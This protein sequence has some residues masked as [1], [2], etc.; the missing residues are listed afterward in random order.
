MIDP[1]HFLQDDVKRKHLL[2]RKKLVE[3]YL[4]RY[5]TAP[6]WDF[7]NPD[8][9]GA[10]GHCTCPHSDLHSDSD[11]RDDIFRIWIDRK[12]PKTHRSKIFFSCRHESCSHEVWR[13]CLNVRLLEENPHTKFEDIDPQSTPDPATLIKL[14]AENQH[15]I[16]SAEAGRDLY[17][18]I[19]KDAQRT[20]FPLSSITS[21][22]PVKTT[23]LDHYDQ[24]LLQLS[25]YHPGSLLWIGDVFDAQNKYCIKPVSVWERLVIQD[26]LFLKNIEGEPESTWPCRG[27]FTSCSTYIDQSLG[28]ND[29]N[30]LTRPYSVCEADYDPEDPS[31]PMPLYKQVALALY[32]IHSTKRVVAIV[33]S[34]SK[35]LHIHIKGT[36]PPATADM[37]AG[38]PR[39]QVGLTIPDNLPKKARYGGMG[40]D[41]A[42]LLNLSQPV[43]LAGHFRQN[44]ERRQSLLYFDPSLVNTSS[45]TL[46]TA[47]PPM[48][49]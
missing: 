49:K 6:T 20:D 16:K 17:R 42:P 38:V 43:R 13:D 46:A 36:I 34:G 8:S 21:I 48:E 30:V 29:D 33:H 40:F 44:T 18:R 27:P 9:D 24:M 41:P 7:E 19:T 10:V 11:D 35:S 2:F 15:R 26:K 37:M 28:R 4:A 3:Q 25:M 45:P 1:L 12:C 47:T 23:K 32:L 39:S 5:S 14:Q 31:N 22:S